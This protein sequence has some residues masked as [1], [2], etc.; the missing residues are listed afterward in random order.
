MVMSLIGEFRK[1]KDLYFGGAE[2]LLLPSGQRKRFKGLQYFAENLKPQSVLA[3]KEFPNYG[4]YLACI[5]SCNQTH[6]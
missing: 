6:P 1:T 2:G 3:V 4:R 5:I